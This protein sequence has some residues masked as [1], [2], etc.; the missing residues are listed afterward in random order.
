M[1][2]SNS[3][4]NK[5]IVSSG[6]NGSAFNA[7]LKHKDKFY[8]GGINSIFEYQPIQNKTTAIANLSRGLFGNYIWSLAAAS[9]STLLAGHMK[10]LTSYNIITKKSGALKYAS[11][12]IPKALN[13]Y[14]FV[15]TKTKG[16][17]AVAENGL[18]LI[19]KNNVIVS[20]YGSLV[21]DKKHHL[22]ITCIY[23]MQ[24]D[25]NGIC[26]IASNGEGLFR[27]DWKN[28][29]T[30]K[31]I[32]LKQFSVNNGLPSMILYRI[33]E[34]G[35]NNLWVS[36]YFGLVR[37]N[38]ATFSTAVYSTREGLT[39]NEFNRTS[40]FKAADGSL[41]FGGIDGVIGFNPSQ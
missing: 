20:Y 35:A 9:D 39:N 24:E 1:C 26:W 40:S 12:K 7:F 3:S 10:G 28:A 19:D 16:L 23:D 18:Y 37:F 22:P 31:T 41:Y 4:S 6:S 13:V 17:V 25:K 14:R 38:T 21:T 15:K 27:W 29:D 36:T 30:D 11:S 5:T 33:E 32:R 34:D 8:V 2:V